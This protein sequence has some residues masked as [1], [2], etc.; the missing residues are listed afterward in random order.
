MVMAEKDTIRND[1]Y[2][3][4][5]LN[6]LHIEKPVTYI[7]FSSYAFG[8]STFTKRQ[9]AYVG[10]QNGCADGPALRPE[11]PRSRLSAVVTWTVGACAESVRVPSFSR[12]LLPKTAGLTRKSVGSGSR[13]PLYIDKGLRPIEPPTIDQIQFITRF[14]LMH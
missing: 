13:P 11:G 12:D 6:N 1:L 14:Y 3:G 2:I 4:A 9:G 10:N 5:L 8:S 7:R